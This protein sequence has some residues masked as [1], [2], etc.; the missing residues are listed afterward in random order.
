M[1]GTFAQPGSV[2]SLEGDVP[3]V[4]CSQGAVFL[5]EV[6][7]EGRNPASGK[8]WARGSRIRQGDVFE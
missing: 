8:D 6:Q 7:P 4:A 2:V 5:L 3:L 1:E